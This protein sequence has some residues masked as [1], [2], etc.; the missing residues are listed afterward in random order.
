M[1][2]RKEWRRSPNRRLV[3]AVFDMLKAHGLDPAK[4]LPP[5]LMAEAQKRIK[6]GATALEAV[7]AMERE[8]KGGKR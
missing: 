1:V 3:D 4:G 5:D 7:E 8:K 6:D 2:M